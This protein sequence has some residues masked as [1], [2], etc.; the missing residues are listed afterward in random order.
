[1]QLRGDGERGWRLGK[2]R[3]NMN[4]S[5]FRIKQVIQQFWK[6]NSDSAFLKKTQHETIKDLKVTLS[7][8]AV[9][10]QRTSCD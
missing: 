3:N 8:I 6:F 4:S 9:R 5:N 7:S 1:M 10:S 2:Y